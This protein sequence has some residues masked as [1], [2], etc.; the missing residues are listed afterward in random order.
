MYFWTN[1][2]FKYKL[3]LQNTFNTA[4]YFQLQSSVKSKLNRNKYQVQNNAQNDRHLN[5]VSKCIVPKKVHISQIYNTC[6]TFTNISK[7]RVCRVTR[8]TFKVQ[9]EGPNVIRTKK[10]DYAIWVIGKI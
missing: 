3:K 9:N 2:N 6:K 5:V 7:T 1:T 8:S 10:F 4:K